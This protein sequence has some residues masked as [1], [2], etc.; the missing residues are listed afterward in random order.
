MLAMKRFFIIPVLFLP[1]MFAPLASGA[2]LLDK[3]RGTAAYFLGIILQASDHLGA[4]DI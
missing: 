2:G 4:Y 3:V 1:L